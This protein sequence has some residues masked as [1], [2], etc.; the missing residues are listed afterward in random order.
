MV[1]MNLAMPS[2]SGFDATARLRSDWRTATAVVI[3]L[4]AHSCPELLAKALRDGC[5]HALVKPCDLTHLTDEIRRRL[6]ARTMG[7]A[8]GACAG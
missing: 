1:L 8:R 2:M 4:T 5:D 3:A 7:A 6:E